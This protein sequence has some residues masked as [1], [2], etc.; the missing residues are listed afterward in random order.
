[1]K[2]LSIKSPF[3]IF[4][5]SF[6]LIFIYLSNIYPNF[7]ENW[8]MAITMLFGSI[9]AGATCE[10]GGA[11]AFPVMTLIFKIKPA[12]ARDFSLLIQSFGMI[13]A[14]FIILKN[15]IKVSKNLILICLGGSFI[16]Q[17]LAMKFLLSLFSPVLTKITFTSIWLSFCLVLFLVDGSKNRKTDIDTT[18]KNIIYFTILSMIGGTITALTG[19]GVDIVTFSFATLYLGLDEKIATPTSVILMAINSVIGVILKVTITDVGIAREAIN[20]WLV[21]LPVVIFGAP[22]GAIFIHD[23]SKKLIIRFLQF[24][25]IAQ[26]IASWI[27]LE[28]TINLKL[29]SIFLVILGSSIY[30]Y[31]FKR[32]EKKSFTHQEE[33]FEVNL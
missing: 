9:I 4:A 27:I 8:F 7:I 6:W 2:Q 21:C 17:A 25:I 1:M 5:L 29:W 28:L 16:G 19:S 26:F 24:S 10:G 22:L 3:Q 30:F 15:K 32:R 14:S 33:I 23:K 18:K 13:S 31:L 11:V 12:I 20:Y